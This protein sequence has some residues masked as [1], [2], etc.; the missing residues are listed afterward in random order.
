MDV[1]QLLLIVDVHNFGGVPQSIVV[2]GLESQS[3]RHVKGNFG[4]GI[5]FEIAFHIVF[6][7]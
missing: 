6:R 7:E 2:F 5:P 1:R 4:G 3:Q